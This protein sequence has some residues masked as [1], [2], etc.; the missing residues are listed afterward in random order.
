MRLSL[1]GPQAAAIDRQQPERVDFGPEQP[2]SL[3]DGSSQKPR[4][5]FKDE[6]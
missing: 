6:N 1:N 5:S 3:R 2:A 4:V